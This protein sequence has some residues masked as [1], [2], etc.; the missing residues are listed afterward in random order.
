MTI[1]NARTPLGGAIYPFLERPGARWA[2][3][4]Y[5]VDQAPP[6]YRTQPVLRWV[7]DSDVHDLYVEAMHY[8]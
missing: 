1:V 8:P 3:I 4:S 7:S 6:H 2:I 5:T